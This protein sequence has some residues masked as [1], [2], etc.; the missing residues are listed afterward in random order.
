MAPREQDEIV[1]ADAL[2][3]LWKEP[4]PPKLRFENGDEAQTSQRKTK[5]IG[6]HQIF[7]RSTLNVL[8]E[9]EDFHVFTNKNSFVH[10]EEDYVRA[11]GSYGATTLYLFRSIV[12]ENDDN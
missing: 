6:Q 3:S 12:D 5:Y 7:V 10:L 11:G 2:M 8:L 4:T 9:K 1:I